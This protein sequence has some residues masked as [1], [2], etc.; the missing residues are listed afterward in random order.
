MLLIQALL[1]LAGGIAAGAWAYQH[2]DDW[3]MRY[4]GGIPM[5]EAV[6]TAVLAFFTWFI[7]LSQMVPISL[8]VSGEMVKFIMSRFINWDTSLYHAP[9]AKPAHCNSSTI[10]E[11]LGLIDYVFSDKTGTLTQNKMEFRFALLNNHAEFGSRET[12]IAKAVTQRNTELLQRQQ[13]TYKPTPMPRWTA[14]M[15]PH[16][17]PRTPSVET[18]YDIECC[19]RRCPR[20]CWWMWVN[21][22]HDDDASVST[23]DGDKHLSGNNGGNARDGSGSSVDRAESFGDSRLS[24]N[25]GQPPATAE[26]INTDPSSRIGGPGAVAKPPA[27]A[28]ADAVMGAALSDE[29]NPAEANTF[30]SRERAALLRALYAPPPAGTPTAELV[31]WETTRARLEQYM[32]HMALSNTVKPFMKN[33]KLEFQP[34]SAEELAMCQFAHRCGFTKLPEKEDKEKTL[35]EKNSNANTRVQIQRY[36]AKLR[37]VG[38]PEERRYA[39]LACLGFTSQR[40][41]VTVIYQDAQ[42][43]EILIMIKGQDGMVLP[44]LH[45][46]QEAKFEEKLLAELKNLSNNGLRTLI[47]GHSTRP[48]SWWAETWGPKYR[49]CKDLVEAD[50]EARRKVEHELFEQIEKDC[51]FEYLGCLGMEDQLQPLVPDCIQSCLRAGVK[52]WMITGDKLET[53]RNIGLACNLIDA[54]MQP[55]IHAGDTLATAMSAFADSRL[56][57]VTGEWHSMFENA[58]ELGALFDSIDYN[59]DGIVSIEELTVLLQSLHSGIS[60][61]IIRN[62]TQLLIDAEADVASPVPSPGNERRPSMLRLSV[63][64][65]AGASG[66]GANTDTPT[67]SRRIP[68]HSVPAKQRHSKPYDSDDEEAPTAT[69]ARGPLAPPP[70]PPPPPPPAPGVNGGKS[71]AEIA[72]QSLRVQPTHRETVRP[73]S[74]SGVADASASNQRPVRLAKKSG[75]TKQGFMHVMRQFKRTPYEAVSYDVDEGIKRYLRIQ[76]PAAF[77][78]SLLVNRDAFL[79]MFPGKQARKRSNTVGSSGNSNPSASGA[80]SRSDTASGHGGHGAEEEHEVSEAQ[81]EKL[82]RKFFFLASVSK[83][84]VFA[85]AQPAMKKKMVTEIQARVPK[86]VTLAIGDGAN[87]TDMIT[88]AHIGVGIS[89]VEGTAATNSA[90]YA[91]GTFRMLHTLLFVHGYWSYQR[92]SNLV[93]FIFY[94]AALVAIV[95]FLFGFLSGFSGQ[96]FFNDP[97]YQ[98]YNVMFTAL[99]IISVSVLDKALPRNTCEDNPAVFREE[100]RK[101]FNGCIFFSWL[102]RSLVHGLIVFWVPV[103]SLGAGVTQPSDGRVTGLWFVSTTVFFATVLLPTFFIFFLMQSI[104]I[105]HIIAVLCSLLA[106]YVVPI[107]LNV[108]AFNSLNPDLQGEIFTQFSSVSYWLTVIITLAI[109][110]LF[111]LGVRFAMRLFRPTLTQILQEKLFLARKTEKKLTTLLREAEELGTGETITYTSSQMPAD[112]SSNLGATTSGVGADSS[113]GGGFLHGAVIAPPAPTHLDDLRPSA[114]TLPGAGALLSPTESTL[115]ANVSKRLSLTTQPDVAVSRTAAGGRRAVLARPMISPEEEERWAQVT[116]GSSKLSSKQNALVKRLQDEA[117]RAAKQA[118]GSDGA[119]GEFS[120]GETHEEKLRSALVRAMLRFRNQTGAQFDSAAQ[121]KYQKVDNM[122]TEPVPERPHSA[123]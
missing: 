17:P 93:S 26:L 84:V 61:D 56:I 29:Y 85:R 104:N 109:P 20:C 59:R 111:E 94:K 58:D 92:I 41:R 119:G 21:S 49:A 50:D 60:D 47:A 100:K 42:T 25:L 112:G 121:A 87:D 7:N 23:Y 64:A 76:D 86:A 65:E 57:Q 95:Q 82:R 71:G 39:F 18:G 117:V 37:P 63:G 105:F 96:Q 69:A 15:E 62:A 83:S 114:S 44:L 90:D 40:A 2:G 67:H 98:L 4:S 120:D 46:P 9:I 113:L 89:G 101:A 22:K 118:C 78:V 35:E 97:I 1:C 108:E 19:R 102:M 31:A 30:N 54:D 45:L 48:A 13:G 12:E 81:L 52:V 53:A 91:I 110:I 99:P 79:V 122:I 32:M 88:A 103:L 77:P 6:L 28:G 80:R 33:G 116:G 34:E 123:R 72:L 24:S 14:L 66:A 106:L 70:P 75:I 107:L 55:Q 115:T 5:S 10:H 74:G 16:M 43:Q 51:T 3:Y 27:N 73:H 11:D 8:I 36:D 68:K 38:Q